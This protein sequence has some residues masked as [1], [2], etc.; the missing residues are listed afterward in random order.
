VIIIFW[1]EKYEID[2]E[3]RGIYT[4][5]PESMPLI[6]VVY[7]TAPFFS[8]VG[9]EFRK[10]SYYYNRRDSLIGTPV[11]FE[12]GSLRIVRTVS[13]EQSY[14]LSDSALPLNMDKEL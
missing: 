2:S 4:M 9:L 14:D 8:P 13:T 11:P 10:I 5:R 7:G 12:S 1:G 6:I 3:G